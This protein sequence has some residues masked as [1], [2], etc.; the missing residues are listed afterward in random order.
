VAINE[1]G[2]GTEELN[3]NKLLPLFTYKNGLVKSFSD[4]T[5]DLVPDGIISSENKGFKKYSERNGIF[6]YDKLN[7]ADINAVGLGQ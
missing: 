7:R 6:G 2:S 4:D 5:D 3:Y 1:E